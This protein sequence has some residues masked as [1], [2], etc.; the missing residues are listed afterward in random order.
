M[1]KIILSLYLILVSTLAL[2][3]FMPENN[4]NLQ[5]K[6][7]KT[8]IEYEDYNFILD[9]IEETYKPIVSNFGANLIIDQE[10]DSSTVNAYAYKQGRDWFVVIHGGLARRPELNV[11]SIA[12][13]VC[14]EL[15]HHL[16]G[17]PF[18]R[19]SNMANEGQSDYFSTGACFKKYLDQ[20]I[21]MGKVEEEAIE[22]CGEKKDPSINCTRTITAAMGLTNLLNR[23]YISPFETSDY[24]T[25]KMI[26]EHPPA[27]CRFD[28]Y[29]AGY[30]C[31][32]KWDDTLIPYS[33]K[34]SYKVAC[35]KP[36][37]WFK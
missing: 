14:H 32:K 13:V 37:C 17:Y 5:D 4:L 24:I 21:F 33:R 26:N 9:L 10:W 7:F 31:T 18:Y 28:T 30:F 16:G 6:R 23:G 20:T 15:G 12:M 35:S 1:K 29:K 22:Y 19:W 11:D 25:D 27:V 2:A 3:S 34:E 8:A 36:R